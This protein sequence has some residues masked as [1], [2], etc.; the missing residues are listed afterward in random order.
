MGHQSEEHTHKRS[1]EEDLEKN[2]PRGPTTGPNI[3]GRGK[4]T[5]VLTNHPA[6]QKAAAAQRACARNYPNK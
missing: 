6:R 1:P 4:D 3:V 2:I 5:G